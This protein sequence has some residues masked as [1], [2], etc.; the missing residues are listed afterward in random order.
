MPTCLVFHIACGTLVKGVLA[1]GMGLTLFIGSVYVMLSAVFG[2]WMGYLVLAVSFFG[3]MIVM[4]TLWATG[5]LISGGPTTVKNQG[6]R[7]SEP[8]WVVLSAGPRTASDQYHVFATYPYSPWKTLGPGEAGS[9]QSASSAAQGFLADQANAQLHIDPLA[10][11]AIQGTQF[12]IS[13]IRFAPQGSVSLAVARASFTGGGPEIIVSLRHDSG[14][15]GRYS[16]MFLVGSIV[17]F[18]LHV[19]LLDRAEKKR[20]EFL[21]GGAAPAWY[22][23]A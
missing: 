21:T 6:P 17:L 9:V 11:N 10:P 4:S 15:I 23:P 13:D 5:F 8:S 3:W 18:G 2:R 7:G 1:V 16:A 14:S 22:G 20:K 12:V 19:P